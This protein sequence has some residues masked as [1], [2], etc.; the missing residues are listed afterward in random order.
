MN[1]IKSI[2]YQMFS[3]DAIKAAAL[4]EQLEDMK[5]C[6]E[7]NMNHLKGGKEQKK[8]EEYCEKAELHAQKDDGKTFNRNNM[9]KFRNEVDQYLKKNPKA[10]LFEGLGETEHFAVRKFYYFNVH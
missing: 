9:Q 1:A 2:L 3:A 10:T 7:H 5:Y 8:W 4:A 6:A